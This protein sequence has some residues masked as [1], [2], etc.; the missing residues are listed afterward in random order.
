MSKKEKQMPSPRK[1]DELKEDYHKRL[2]EER[3]TF[4]TKLKGKVI[5]N[6]TEQGTYKKPK[7]ETPEAK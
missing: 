3:Q 4:E 5:W 6:S 2:K 1:P 7:D